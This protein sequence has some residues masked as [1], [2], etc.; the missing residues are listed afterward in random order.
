MRQGQQPAKAVANENDL[1]VTAL[2][3]PPCCRFGRVVFAGSVVRHSF[4]WP[5]FQPSQVQAVL[6]YV[7]TA[8]WVVAGFPNL[9]EHLQLLNRDL[10]GAGHRGF[11]AVA[12]NLYIDGCHGAAIREENCDALADY[13]YSG[14]P[15]PA[16]TLPRNP[17]V[18]AIGAF[19][20]VAWVV[21]LFV[22]LLVGSIIGILTCAAVHTS[23]ARLEALTPHKQSNFFL[24]LDKK[25]AAALAVA[26]VVALAAVKK[27]LMK[28]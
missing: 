20:P 8:D 14:G 28:L 13:V 19:P 10:G 1:P 7:A 26:V 11:A 22:A 2:E 9:F 18:T 6:N 15:V 5:R 23:I 16:A 3:L 4:E 25:G 21:A 12:Q 27:A 17:L 24:K